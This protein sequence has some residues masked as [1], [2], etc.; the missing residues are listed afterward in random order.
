M[1]NL[2]Q[3]R[4]HAGDK[5]LVYDPV[6]QFLVRMAL[7]VFTG[8]YF[9]FLPADNLLLQR[10]WILFLVSAYIVYHA[11]SYVL[12]LKKGPSSLGINA[13]NWVDLL[14]AG[15]TIIVDPYPLPPVLM[16]LLIVILG[17]GI[18][19]GLD[20]FNSG[21]RKGL[22]VGAACVVFHF[23]LQMRRPSYPFYAYVL[24][25]LACIVYSYI[26]VRRVETLKQKAESLAHTD[27]LT[28]MLNRRAFSETAKYLLSLHERMP[29]K[30]VFVF[31]D[32]DEFKKINDT[33]GH[34]MGDR[35]LRKFAELVQSNCRSTDVICRYGGDEFI[36]ILINSEIEE[37]EKIMRRL[38]GL[39]KEWGRKNSITFGISWGMISPEKG[40]NDLSDIL[41]KAD[42]DLYREKMAKKCK[43]DR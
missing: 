35:V 15:I 43:V 26:L 22:I 31:A 41:K 40:P 18:Q 21:V 10:K 28:G 5:P 3:Y 34:E 25:I 39:L 6:V 4:V 37:A 14:G 16:L 11:V 19:H 20:N 36:F 13:G 7:G 27:E 17:N 9:Y 42:K 2:P 1:K 8:A 12:F 23:I 24:F 38:N 32:L 30:L 29:M 33:L